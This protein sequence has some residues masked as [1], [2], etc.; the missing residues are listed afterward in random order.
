M[1]LRNAVV[2]VTGASRGIGRVTARDLAKQGAEVVGVGRDEAALAEVAAATGGTSVVCDV[3]DPG[4]VS[5]IADHLDSGPG[6][7]DAVVLN[8]GIGYA[9]EFVEMS[10]DRISDLLDVNLR[11]PLLLARELAPRLVEQRRGALVFVSS[12]AGLLPVPDEAV[13]SATKNGMQAFA[14]ALRE[15]LRGTGVTVS[16]VSPGVVSTEFFQARGKPY[17]RRFPRPIAPERIS[18]A[19]VDVLRTGK[20]HRTVPRWFDGPAR[21]RG[22][23]PG[24]YRT[25]SRLGT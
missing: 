2:V 18:A 23:M 10:P 1:E 5:V 21:L 9:G 14:E 6:R 8:A 3:S 20:P 17:D 11:G 24:V 25:L 22:A 19:I 4:H 12:I 13:Y 7:L 15:E 16:T